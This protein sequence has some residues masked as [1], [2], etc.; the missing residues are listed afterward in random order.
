M[1]KSALGLITLAAASSLLVS[2]CSSSGSKTTTSSTAGSSSAPAGGSS[3]S[4]APAAKGK[5]GVILPDTTSSTRYT[6]YDAPLLKKAFDAAGIQSDIQ[7]SG[8]STAKQGS[9]ADSM[10]G[11]GVKVIL[12]DSIDATSGAAIEAKAAAAG[13]Q[14][15]DYDRV[16]LGGTAP[17]YVSFDNEEVGKLQ[18]S[19]LVSCL[20]AAKKTNPQIIEMDGGKDVDNN[21]VLF[22]KGAAEVF[23]PLQAAGK[24]KVVS[25]T[26]VKGWDKNLAAPAFQQALTANGGKVDG[27]LAANDDIANE[28]ITVLKNKGLKVP[29]TGQDAGISG[30]Q[31]ILKGDQCMT[32]F[33][34]VK[35]EADAASKLAI[36]LINK[37]D[38]TTAGNLADFA[39][40][41]TPSH[42]IKAL[43]LK[44]AVI[45]IK[46]VE[47]VVTAGSLKASDIC[48]GI[49]SLCTKNGVK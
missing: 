37:Q 33:K 5:V 2:A 48:K 34:D 9:I 29:V 32:V 44:P 42:K 39:D 4:S 22:A 21:A 46:N 35:Q 25:K 30:L 19:T 17:Y 18:A 24:L 16:N 38:P 36:A 7:N 13:I 49:E 41:K 27:V 28:V 15:I 26:T 3:S 1:R 6:L 12:I 20:T 43:L 14:V 31:N 8:G 40:P 10:I 45:T 11:E 23:D 47:D